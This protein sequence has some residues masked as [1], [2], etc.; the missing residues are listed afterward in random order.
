MFYITKMKRKS[1]FP[2][3]LYANFYFTHVKGSFL[4]RKRQK[5]QSWPGLI[6]RAYYLVTGYLGPVTGR[7]KSSLIIGWDPE[8]AAWQPETGNW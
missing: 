8:I 6:C 1:G 2:K 5:R 7:K 3:K 4:G